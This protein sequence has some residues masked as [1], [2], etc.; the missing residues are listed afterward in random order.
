MNYYNSQPFTTLK[1]DLP[2]SRVRFFIPWDAF[3]TANSSGQCTNDT[4]STYTS[5]Q[6]TDILTLFYSLYTAGPADAN[7]GVT[8]VLD[9]GPLAVPGDTKQ[10]TESQYICGFGYLIQAVRS[11][12]SSYGFASYANEYEVYNEPDAEGICSSVAA[13]YYLDAIE[14]DDF[15]NGGHV[16]DSL[17]IGAFGDRAMNK[18]PDCGGGQFVP[19][20]MSNAAND[21]NYGCS[22]SS[23]LCVWPEATSGHPYDDPDNTYCGSSSCDEAQTSWL[24]QEV[25]TGFSGDPVFLTETAVWLTDPTAAFCAAGP[26]HPDVDAIDNGTDAACVDDNPTNQANAAQ[27]WLNLA[28]VPQV[29]RVYWYQYQASPNWDSALLAASGQARPSYCV[30]IHEGTPSWCA[31]NVNDTSQGQP[32][33]QDYEDNPGGTQH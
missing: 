5:Q 31:A 21:Y 24:V 12:W 7:L 11:T 16:Y 14:A 22:M 28:S 8:V 10:P 33:D 13:E 3:G 18:G 17:I 15:V 29:Y 32:Y 27:T 23:A 2:V 9:G 1:T 20:Y 25:N 26:G 19:K 30:L 6:Q 4:S